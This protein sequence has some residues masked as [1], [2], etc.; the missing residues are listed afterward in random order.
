[1]FIV[2]ATEEKKRRQKVTNP[3]LVSTFGAK[4]FVLMA[5]IILRI[6]LER[7]FVQLSFE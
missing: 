5:L 1:M 6:L 7:L 3:L 4:P 2:Q